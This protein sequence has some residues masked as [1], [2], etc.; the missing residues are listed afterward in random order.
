[1]GPP[2]VLHPCP[3][4]EYT[5]SFSLLDVSEWE[6]AAMPSLG[7]IVPGGA[8]FCGT[9]VSSPSDRLS[10]V[11]ADTDRMLVLKSLMSINL[12][13]ADTPAGG[14]VLPIVGLNT[15]HSRR[16]IVPSL[17]YTSRRCDPTRLFPL[18]SRPIMTSDSA[19]AGKSSR[20]KWL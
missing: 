15:K 8:D 7:L 19:R 1:M 16:A 12:V 5:A 17:V 6:F 14:D 10:S 18:H 4:R 3:M 2:E 13:I 9:L 20:S 11:V